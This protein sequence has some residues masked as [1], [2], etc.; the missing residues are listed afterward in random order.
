MTYTNP[1]TD[2]TNITPT[3]YDYNGASY[4]KQARTDGN[5]NSYNVDVAN[6]P[7]PVVP[8]V[9][10]TPAPTPAPTTPTTANSTISNLYGTTSQVSNDYGSYLNDTQAYERSKGLSEGGEKTGLAGELQRQ[11]DASNALYAQKLRE[12]KVVGEAR[13]GATRSGELN[14]GTVGG[15]VATAATDVTT[16]SNTGVYNQIEE[17]RVMAEAGVRS[18]MAQKAQQNYDRKS[19]AMSGNLKDRIA[20]L[21]GRDEAEKTKGVEVA[22]YLIANGTDTSSITEEEAKKAGT[23]L[24]E[25]KS[26]FTIKQYTTKKAASEEKRKREQEL[27]DKIAFEQAKPVSVNEGQRMYERDPKT[28]KLVQTAYNP[29]TFAPKESAAKGVESVIPLTAEGKVQKLNQL[30]TI[31]T[32]ATKVETLAERSGSNTMW[33]SVKQGVGGATGYTNL[34]AQTNSL[35]VQAM[36]VLSDPNNKKFFGPAMS[37]ADVQLMMAGGNPMN[38]ELQTPKE[39]KESL[40]NLTDAVTEIENNIKSGKVNQITSTDTPPATPPST[41]GDYVSPKGIVYRVGADGSYY[42]VE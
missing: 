7:A 27:A 11:I 14:R 8:T 31:R 42:P 41:S 5:G 25:I 17:D 16:A 18:M 38:P 20:F 33:E 26:A 23:S 35:R 12:A 10:N 39:L 24:A 15:N 1:L 30:T 2:R 22:D 13:L 32:L 40:K 29:K 6:T 9:Q 28:G 3:S 36:T 34:V 19:A 37:N 21:K 4:T